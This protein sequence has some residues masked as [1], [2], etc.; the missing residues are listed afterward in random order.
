[1]PAKLSVNINA[2]A[3]NWVANPTS[4]TPEILNAPD[5][6]E[7]LKDVPVSRVAQGWESAA[8]ALYLSSTESNFI[9]GQ[10]IA[11]AGGWTA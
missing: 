6:A 8:L 7:R 1:M 10:T 3:Q 4:Y 5:F 2:I 11:F 9:C